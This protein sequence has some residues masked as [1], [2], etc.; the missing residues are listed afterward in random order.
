MDIIISV[1]ISSD[2]IDIVTGSNDGLFATVA[3]KKTEIESECHQLV[4]SFRET[5]DFVKAELKYKLAAINNLTEIIKITVNEI[6]ADESRELQTIKVCNKGN[7]NDLVSKMLH[8]DQLHH[9][10]QKLKDQ[11]HNPTNTPGI[12]V[13]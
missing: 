11:P 12:F 7:D 5:I 3:H 4:G 8:T 2:C 13:E 9:R 1:V 10:F 6:N